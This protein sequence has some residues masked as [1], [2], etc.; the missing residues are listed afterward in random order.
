MR[1]RLRA[2]GTTT[3]VSRESCR[4]KPSQRVGIH[5]TVSFSLPS[6]SRKEHFIPRRNS[7]ATIPR[8]KSRSRSNM[9][10]NNVSNKET[11][12]V[13]IFLPSTVATDGEDFLLLQKQ[14][15]SI[16]TKRAK[17][18]CTLSQEF[19]YL[20]HWSIGTLAFARLN[21]SLVR[22]TNVELV[23]DTYVGDQKLADKCV[24]SFSV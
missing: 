4:D 17:K 21:R 19:I 23:V 7:R 24:R 6:R 2:P 3:G 15:V 14:N 20:I 1:A 18:Q 12:C 10:D 13:T 9:F 8:I 22:R 11:I 5:P 16:C